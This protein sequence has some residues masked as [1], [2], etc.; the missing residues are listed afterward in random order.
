[1][2]YTKEPWH[3]GF[4][5]T[6]GRNICAP[7][8]G[9]IIAIVE[10]DDDARRIVACVNACAGISTEVLE[11]GPDS[12]YM[13]AKDI[14]K[15]RDDLTADIATLDQEARQVRARLARVE[16]ERDRLLSALSELVSL[17]DLK[18][19]SESAESSAEHD[20]CGR[21]YQQRKPAAWKAAREE[22]ARVKGGEK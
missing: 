12:V 11:R 8:T 20:Y 15:Q 9:K 5:V 13:Y 2:S 21:E 19:R 3:E 14:A 7:I 1:M 16:G 6:G 18:D 10:T 22:V 17:K 4:K